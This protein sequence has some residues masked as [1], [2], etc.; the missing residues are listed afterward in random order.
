MRE[1]VEKDDFD[2]Y[3]DRNL[4]FHNVYLASSGNP[5][6]LKIINTMKKRLY[7]FPR[8]SKFVKE[9]ELVSVGEHAQLIRLLKRRSREEAAAFVRDVHWSFQVQE[10]FIARYYA[11]AQAAADAN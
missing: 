8:P 9:W 7:D 4:K 2:L 11:D 1:A 6:L 10:K 3:Y 5:I